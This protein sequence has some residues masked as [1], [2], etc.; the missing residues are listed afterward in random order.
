M[1]K[2]R[3]FGVIVL[4]EMIQFFRNPLLVMLVLYAFTLDIFTAANGIQVKPRNIGVGILDYTKGGVSVKII[5]HLH[6]PDF[7]KPVF[8]TSEQALKNAIYEKKIMLGVIFDNNFDK[9][10]HLE[11]IADATA[12]AQ[13]QLAIIYLQNILYNTFVKEKNIKITVA[14]HKLFNQNSHT[15]W[16]MGLSEFMSMTTM[17]V[18]LLSAVS[19]V[20]EKEK[21]T[22]DIMLLTPV[23]SKITIFAKLFSQ[24]LVIFFGVVIATGIIIF[25]VLDTPIHGSF[26][27]FLLSTVIFA[28]SI[29]GIG[30]F[31]AS[32]S[33]TILEVAEL[34]FLIMMPLIF[35][36]GAWTP[37][38]EMGI[39]NQVLSFF[40]P[41][42]YYIELTQD[43]FFRGSS[44]EV[45][46]QNLFAMIA[47]G[48]F[49]FWFG[50]R[51]IGKLF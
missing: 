5:S 50:Y 6:K 15:P 25:K 27:L 28:F 14:S 43:I 42:R 31:I 51:K 8:Y 34:S 23:D 1:E 12:A 10:H 30:L 4:K 19:F 16:F 36:S 38:F 46:L 44:I 20:K 13:S 26:F 33:E 35:L 3:D 48:S 47:I 45:I 39:F 11:I 22:W 2:I 9:T 18:L 29:A 40:S 37:V 49:L 7:K 41:L 24:I 21:G 32:V 17:I